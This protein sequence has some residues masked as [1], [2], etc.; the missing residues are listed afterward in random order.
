MRKTAIVTLRP[1]KA[2]ASVLFYVSVV[3][4]VVHDQ[5]AVDEVEAV[6]FGRVRMGDHLFDCKTTKAATFNVKHSAQQN[7]RASKT[8][9]CGA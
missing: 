6:R 1:R 8:G 7:S 4:F 2:K 5:L 3:R 9:S